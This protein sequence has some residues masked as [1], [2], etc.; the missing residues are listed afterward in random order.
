MRDDAAVDPAGLRGRRRVS[1]G[2][3][4]HARGGEVEDLIRAGKLLAGAEKPLH[5]FDERLRRFRRGGPADEVGDVEGEE[6][7]GVEKLLDAGQSDVVGV[8]TV[9]VAPAGVANGGVGRPPRV[10]RARADQGMFPVGLVPDRR[11]GDAVAPRGLERG[12]LCD[13]LA[14]EAVADADRKPL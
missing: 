5:P 10:L 6:V 14:P 3:R 2:R 12:E 1:G 8:E 9:G 11:H 7:A 13:T 4:L